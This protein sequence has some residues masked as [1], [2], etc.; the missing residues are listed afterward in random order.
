[1]YEYI[2]ALLVLIILYWYFIIYDI[3]KC[4]VIRYNDSNTKIHK[5][6]YF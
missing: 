1:M 5:F 4:I 2:I 3:N 6:K